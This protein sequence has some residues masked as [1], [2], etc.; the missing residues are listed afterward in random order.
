MYGVV[1]LLLIIKRL[2]GVRNNVGCFNCAGANTMTANRSRFKRFFWF[3]VGVALVSLLLT[4]GILHA[5]FISLASDPNAMPDWQGTLNLN[6]TGSGGVN[7]HANIDY[8]VYAPATEPVGGNFNSTFPGQDPSNGSQYVYAYQIF[9]IGTT[10]DAKIMS[11]T[12]GLDGDIYESPANIN[13][14]NNPNLPVGV[15]VYSMQFTGTPP[16]SANWNYLISNIG[17]G[18]R[19]K[20][21]MFTSPCP[22][23][24]DYASIVGTSVTGAT[25]NLPSPTPEPATLLILGA[26]G[27]L[28]FL[29][30]KFPRHLF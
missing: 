26:A 11:F 24:W 8:A 27:S 1:L 18:G 10:G 3:Y 6:G 23:E 7:I 17:L 5:T 13:N 25:G 22:P 4:P 21:L 20:I 2:F 28:F 30:R 12:V 16:T 19:S 9:N 14:F 15:N 29:F